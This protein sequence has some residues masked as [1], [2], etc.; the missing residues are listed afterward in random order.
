MEKAEQ[1]KLLHSLYRASTQMPQKSKAGLTKE[2]YCYLKLLG[3]RSKQK[4]CELDSKDKFWTSHKGSPFPNVAE[5]IQE[6]LE[7]YR[8][9]EEEVKKLK[10]SMGI[11]NESE[12]AV[13]MVTDNTAKITSAVQSLPQLLE[14][15]RLIDMHTSLA[16]GI[17]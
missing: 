13:A 2:N 7:Q 10:S 17:Y 14:K 1:E 8:S 4:T 3:A 15:K 9:S 5:A 12:G 16:T 11:D 6:E